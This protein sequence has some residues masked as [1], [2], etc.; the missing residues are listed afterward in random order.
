MN[1]NTIL[2]VAILLLLA[3]G[4]YAIQNKKTSNPTPKSQTVNQ[5]VN[6]A[7]EFA[8]AIE[9][10]R[11]T[12]CTMTNTT[13]K[14]EYFIKGKK[15][16]INLSNIIENKTVLSHIINDEK[17][18]YMWTDGSKQGSKINLLVSPPLAEATPTTAAKDG[19]PKFESKDDYEKLKNSGYTI[20]CKPSNIDET[21]FVPPANV[22]FIDPS[23]IMRSFTTPNSEGKFDASKL[24]E[25]Q[26]QYG[27]TEVN[28]P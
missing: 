23:E 14:M 22:D 16:Y 6:E 19:T 3:G 12:Q 11:P 15:M 13:D 5:A 20:N 8:K 26:N 2:G 4:F 9:S 25:L 21:I 7:E 18:Y 1:K 17:Y 24:Q 10:G 27:E 28:N